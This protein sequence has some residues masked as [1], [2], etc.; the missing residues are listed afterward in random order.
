MRRLKESWIIPERWM[1]VRRSE[2]VRKREEEEHASSKAGGRAR[3][4]HMFW[5][6]GAGISGDSPGYAHSIGG[7]VPCH[8][9][10]LYSWI[11][12]PAN[13]DVDSAHSP[14]T[15]KHSQGPR[16]LSAE[17][18][19]AVAVGNWSGTSVLFSRDVCVTHGKGIG[20]LW[21]LAG[22]VPVSPRGTLGNTFGGDLP[23]IEAQRI[24]ILNPEAEHRSDR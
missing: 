12:P 19:L 21:K 22:E 3:F 7:R 8:V 17:W 6:G 1:D 2:V 11:I 10:H 24:R 5:Q 13:D 9:V 18:Q 15:Q 16:E 4:R 14:S 20:K 23:R